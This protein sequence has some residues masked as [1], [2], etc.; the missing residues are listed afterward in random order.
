[1]RCAPQVVELTRRRDW[2]SPVSRTFQGRDIIAPVA[3]RLA[4]GARLARF[5]RPVRAYATLPLPRVRTTKGA[6][7]GQILFVDPFGNLI[8]NLPQELLART[9]EPSVRF[10][11]RRVRVVS[12]YGEGQPGEWIALPG[13]T[14]YLEL[15]IREQS[16]AAVG[17]RRGDPVQLF[18]GSC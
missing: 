8:T 17:G 9:P 10:R 13:S 11:R 18:R 2:L 7:H 15:A 12:S 5:G 6:V 1:M 3:A 14:G 16:A 4:G